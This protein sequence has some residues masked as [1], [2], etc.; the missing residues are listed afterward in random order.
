M[1]LN[2]SAHKMGWGV[3][4]KSVLYGS[5]VGRIVVGVADGG[6]VGATVVGECVLVAVGCAVF[7]GSRIGVG[8]GAAVIVQAQSA[9]MMMVKPGIHKKVRRM[10]VSHS[11]D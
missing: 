2:A 5:Q 9:N 8:V 1:G 6:F 10:F 4:V 3:G 7:V 11:A